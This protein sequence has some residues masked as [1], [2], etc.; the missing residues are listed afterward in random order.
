MTGPADAVNAALE[1]L[2]L[3]DEALA[4]GAAKLCVATWEEARAL[5]QCANASA[6]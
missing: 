3:F 4:A 2:S 6:S 1:G 5:D